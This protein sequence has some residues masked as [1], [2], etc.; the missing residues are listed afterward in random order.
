M[1]FVNYLVIE[2][3]NFFKKRGV[4]NLGEILKNIKKDK[5]GSRASFQE[6]FFVFLFLIILGFFVLMVYSS[7]I[8]G[9]VLGDGDDV[10]L[11]F[12]NPLPG[13]ILE[14]E[15]VLELS[16]GELIPHNLVFNI[17]LNDQNKEILLEDYLNE[18]FQ[19]GNF[20]LEDTEIEGEGKGY[21]IKGKKYPEVNF[22]LEIYNS[23]DEGGSGEG[24]LDENSSEA[25]ISGENS[26]GE[27]SSGE[28]ISGENSSGEDSSEENIS[29]ENSSGENS[30]GEDS[31]GMGSS[32][33]ESETETGITGKVI[34][35]KNKIVI[36]D[37]ISALEDFK[38]DLKKNQKAKIVS[39]EE[40]VD[41]EIVDQEIKVTTDYYEE[42]FGEEYLGNKSYSLKLN[43]SK[44]GFVAEEG[45]FNVKASYN[46][47]EII[48][49]N[50]E[51]NFQESDENESLLTNMTNDSGQNANLTI[52]GSEEILGNVTINE[53]EMNES[54]MNASEMNASEM[55][56]SGNFSVETVQFDAKVGKL[57]KWKTKITSKNSTINASLDL[58]KHAKNISVYKFEKNEKEKNSIKKNKDFGQE[59]GVR[60]R[61]KIFDELD[62]KKSFKNVQVEEVLEKEGVESVEDR[63]KEVTKKSGDVKI[64]GGGDKG[65]KK[66]NK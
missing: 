46:N 27:N 41:L 14:G 55:N 31:S 32:E 11:N 33:R 51:I 52:N 34:E 38:Y 28:N 30:S 60:K 12:D 40:E 64:A 19:E 59:D 9:M 18:S 56:A 57:V 53:S 4:F 13:E 25:D 43:I 23:S 29:G 47:S 20:Y 48:S 63:D 62:K 6:S 36:N 61:V 7:G 49:L 1:S 3:M 42:G 54:E 65:G 17:W 58:P 50:K 8:S 10:S 66:E 22:V 26:S 45:L 24:G 35:D 37:S 5:K 39:S 21:G 44:L 16:E 15:L 2:K